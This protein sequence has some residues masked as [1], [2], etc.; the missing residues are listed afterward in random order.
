MFYWPQ[1]RVP[2]V[3]QTVTGIGL[4]TVLAGLAGPSGMGPEAG[5]HSTMVS[6]LI[7]RFSLEGLSVLGWDS[8]QLLRI[9]FLDNIICL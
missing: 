1:S 2:L 9:V 7:N 6:S 8:C 4:H 3:D 5:V